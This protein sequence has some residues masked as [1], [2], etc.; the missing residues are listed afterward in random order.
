MLKLPVVSCPR[1]PQCRL[2][3]GQVLAFNSCCELRKARTVKFRLRS[4]NFE[5]LFRRHINSTFLELWLEAQPSHPSGTL[6]SERPEEVNTL[7]REPSLVDV[8]L[9]GLFSFF[10]ESNLKIHHK[11]SKRL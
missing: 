11:A 2:R 4:F 9:N 8:Q 5:P 10:N 3:N 7:R 6:K 1:V